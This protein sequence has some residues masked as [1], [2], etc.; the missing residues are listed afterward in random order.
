MSAASGN[1]DAPRNPSA[2]GA[3]ELAAIALSSAGS[4]GAAV[5]ALQ[6]AA[7]ILEGAANLLGDSRCPSNFASGSSVPVQGV[8]SRK[9]KSAAVPRLD[10][11]PAPTGPLRQPT[12]PYPFLVPA[13]KHVHGIMYHI[14]VLQDDV[15]PGQLLVRKGTV[16]Y[17]FKGHWLDSTF[18]WH[19]ED[20]F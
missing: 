9:R 2:P 13:A 4:P 17:N 16:A 11:G 19:G 18:W 20:A 8:A 5:A 7:S 1:S 3:E 6:E 15:S 12:L 10:L 14:P